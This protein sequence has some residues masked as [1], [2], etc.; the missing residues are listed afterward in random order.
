MGKLIRAGACI[1]ALDNHKQTPLHIIFQKL[2]NYYWEIELLARKQ[3]TPLHITFE[4]LKSDD[5][6]K[7]ELLA[8]IAEQLL[9]SG[10]NLK[11]IQERIEIKDIFKQAYLYEQK[12]LRTT[13]LIAGAETFIKDRDVLKEI[14]REFPI[15]AS[16]CK[17]DRLIRKNLQKSIKA[18]LT[19]ITTDP[20]TPS[21]EH[22]TPQLLRAII[23]IR[24]ERE[25]ITKNPLHYY[26]DE[27]SFL[28]VCCLT[29]REEPE[30][31]IQ[32]NMRNLLLQKAF[33]EDKIPF[34][35]ALTI[36]E[37]SNTKGISRIFNTTS[38]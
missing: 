13:L 38:L 32:T 5:K 27:A 9:K 15:N 26:Y 37:F 14:S 10:A 33:K 23:K 1:D 3:Q 18:L 11:L 30:N 2:K 20:P 36:R 31:N 22:M 25:I 28:S 35:I 8:R 24:W 6:E 12:S 17:Q 21:I 29:N 19:S 34:E 16:A 7:I 4:N